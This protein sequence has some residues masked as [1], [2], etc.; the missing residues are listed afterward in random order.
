MRGVDFMTRLG[1]RGGEE[2]NGYMRSVGPDYFEIM[3]IP[4][5]SGRTLSP[6]DTVAVGPVMVVSEAFARQFFGEENPSAARSRSTGRRMRSSWGSS[7]IPA[8]RR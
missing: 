8:T 3:R 5:L 4:L 2:K 1:P 7:A 6:D